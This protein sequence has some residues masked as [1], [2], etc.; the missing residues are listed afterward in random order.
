MNDKKDTEKRPCHVSGFFSSKKM[1]Q[2]NPA[3][4]RSK[5]GSFARDGEQA[6]W[7]RQPQPK[8]AGL[9]NSFKWRLVKG[10]MPSH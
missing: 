4:I 5:P 9:T 6:E 1:K 3:S 2:K 7:N 8:T 10:E